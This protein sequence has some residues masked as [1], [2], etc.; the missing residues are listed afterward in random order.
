MKS[1]LERDLEAIKKDGRRAASITTPSSY[2]ITS[3][4]RKA[5][6]TG[7]TRPSLLE[8]ETVLRAT[9]KER[10]RSH[11]ALRT[12][13]ARKPFGIWTTLDVSNGLGRDASQT[14]RDRTILRPHP[15]GFGLQCSPDVHQVLRVASIKDCGG[16]APAFCSQKLA[17]VLQDSSRPLL[18]SPT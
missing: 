14:Q 16:K 3:R 7:R 18:V 15:L 2:R 10:A 1:D 8:T 5:K 13:P 4:W 9:A 6:S 11:P 17:T 12:R